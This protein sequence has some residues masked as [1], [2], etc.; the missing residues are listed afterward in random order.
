MGDDAVRATVA[1]AGEV[2][3]ARRRL[4]AQGRP[5]RGV[6]VSMTALLARLAVAIVTRWQT[7]GRGW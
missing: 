6:G 2:V 5:W 3:G 1:V 7:R 4:D